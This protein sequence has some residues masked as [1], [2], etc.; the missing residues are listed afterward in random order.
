MEEFGFIKGSIPLLIS[1]LFWN[2]T[3]L[4]LF[5]IYVT[6]LTIIAMFGYV[7]IT[8]SMKEILSHEN[9]Q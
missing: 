1:Y 4:R 7:F 8:Q 3:D 6:I 2:P 5:R 9:I